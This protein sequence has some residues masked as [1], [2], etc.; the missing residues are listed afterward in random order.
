MPKGVYVRTAETRERCRENGRKSGGFTGRH[1]DES[2][3]KMRAAK[4]GKPGPWLGKVRGPASTETRA[5]MASAAAGRAVPA[6]IREMGN[7]A[8]LGTHQSP[9]TIAKI[10][11]AINRPEAIAKMR[12]VLG[13]P[14]RHAKHVFAYNGRRFR[15]SYEVRT[16]AA[17]DALGIAWTYESRRFDCGAF[18]YAPDFHITHDNVFWEV[19]GWYG[20]D[21]RRKVEAFRRLYPD[22]PLVVFTESCLDALE[23]AVRVAA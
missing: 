19:K 10:K 4:I 20:P 11:A 16:A 1:S 12:A 2:K 18:T 21:S 14:C 8:R 3:A 9:E 22:V 23:A 7:A 13:K 17:L 5:K 6:K 15:S